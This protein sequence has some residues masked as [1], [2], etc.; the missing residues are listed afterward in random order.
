[1]WR[2]RHLGELR[3]RGSGVRISPGAPQTFRS[4]SRQLILLPAP[5]I[6]VADDWLVAAWRLAAVPDTRLDSIS[7]MQHA[8]TDALAARLILADVWTD[9]PF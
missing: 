3:T 4:I 9:A 7:T 1:M 5:P 8:R 6:A 2:K